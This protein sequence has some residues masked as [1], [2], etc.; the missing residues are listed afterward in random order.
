MTNDKPI[1][2][3]SND[4]GINAPG[5]RY[6]IECVA[7]MGH[8]IVAAPDGARSGFASAITV[9]SP[10]RIVRHEDFAGAEMWAINGTPTDCVKLAMNTV[11]QRKPALMLS[12]IN[13]GS[14]SGNSVI[15]SGTM[16]AVLE[17]CMLD[18]PAIGFSLLE[19]S[20]DADFSEC[21]SFIREISGKTLK[22]GL[23]NGICLN[24]NIPARCK[25]LGMKVTHAS[26][27]HWEKEYS[28]HKDAE[29]LPYYKLTGNYVDNDP[30]DSQTDNYWLNRQYVS[31]VPVRPDQTAFDA[32]KQ[33]E[34]QFSI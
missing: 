10:L 9:D 28:H 17:A 22:Y 26:M 33:I 18:I 2:L 7:D 11:V 13:H 23:P 34:H 6:L 15:Y 25:P 8:V 16:G 5:I 19:H 27:G 29:G 31:I 14:N 32:L 1:I 12:G 20:W 3:I 4:D 24:V 21:R 30:N